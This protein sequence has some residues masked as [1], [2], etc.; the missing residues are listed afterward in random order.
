MSKEVKGPDTVC[1]SAAWRRLWEILLTPEP[2]DRSEP[3]PIQHGC[4]VERKAA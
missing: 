1:Q 2:A 3:E 4:H